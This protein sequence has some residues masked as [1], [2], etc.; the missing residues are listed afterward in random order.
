MTDY[1]FTGDPMEPPEE[2]ESDLER[3]R[4]R[5]ER[6]MAESDA[7]LNRS[8]RLAMARTATADHR[9]PWCGR[10]HERDENG[11]WLHAEPTID[12][13]GPPPAEDYRLATSAQPRIE[14]ATIER[15]RR[16][17]AFGERDDD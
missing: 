17:R 1:Q 13:P 16:V 5:R 11:D 7:K 12:C 9:C 10:A 4:A 14:T 8:I 6:E 3:V 15:P 2:I